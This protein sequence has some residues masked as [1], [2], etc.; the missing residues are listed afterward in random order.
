MTPV[1][2]C[3]RTPG[4]I[5]ADDHRA[6]MHVEIEKPHPSF[7]KNANEGATRPPQIR[8]LSVFEVS[9]RH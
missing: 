1:R 6:V 5:D 9:W 3:I 8:A 4:W 7:A 2:F